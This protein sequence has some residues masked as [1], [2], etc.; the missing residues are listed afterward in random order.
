MDGW[1]SISTHL[2]LNLGNVP[3]KGDLACVKYFT[4]KLNSGFLL[5]E[6]KNSTVFKTVI[7]NT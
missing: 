1:I 4:L 6:G 3:F 5:I 7:K 2:P